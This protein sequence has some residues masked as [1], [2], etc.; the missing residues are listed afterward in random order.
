MPP[1]NT[2][3]EHS[4]VRTAAR[5]SSCGSTSLRTLG[6]DT[7]SFAWSVAARAGLSVG[8]GAIILELGYLQ[9]AVDVAALRGNLGGA[10]LAVG[11]ALDL[12]P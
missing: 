3:A 1:I 5:R 8:P 10:Q 11:Y 2:V 7:T 4:R 12:P 9:S 6:V